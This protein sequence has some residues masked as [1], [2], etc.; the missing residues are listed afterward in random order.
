MSS[1]PHALWGKACPEGAVLVDQGSGDPCCIIGTD[2]N[3]H[4]V[5]EHAHTWIIINLLLP[6]NRLIN[7]ETEIQQMI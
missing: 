2:F 5:H 1:H 3:V 7:Y 4:C 6:T